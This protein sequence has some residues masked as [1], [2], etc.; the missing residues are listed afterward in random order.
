MGTL[1][2]ARWRQVFCGLS[3]T[4]RDK[5][6]V[7]SVSL[8][9]STTYIGLRGKWTSKPRRKIQQAGHRLWLTLRY[10]MDPV[11]RDT[12][13]VAQESHPAISWIK[14][15]RHCVQWI[16]PAA[17]L[18]SVQPPSQTDWHLLLLSST[19]SLTAQQMHIVMLIATNNFII[20]II[21]IRLL[22]IAVTKA[23]GCINKQKIR[24]HK[25]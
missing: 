22:H 17:F 18:R 9:A 13:F 25:C 4:E 3:T 15:R 21:I 7:K 6:K 16:S 23:T 5:V 12:K 10:Q 11:S 20:S 8:A 24:I 2:W 14:V 19:H 1:D